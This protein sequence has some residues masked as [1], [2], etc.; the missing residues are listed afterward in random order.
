MPRYSRRGYYSRR[1]KRRR[2]RGAQIPRAIKENGISNNLI[3]RNIGYFQNASVGKQCFQFLPTIGY[4]ATPANSTTTGD[5][6]G[7]L[8]LF[9][10]DTSSTAITLDSLARH[11]QGSSPTLTDD[12]TASCWFRH[13]KM[14]Y[15]LSNQCANQIVFTLYLIKVRR[16]M[17][18]TPTALLTQNAEK[19]TDQTWASEFGFTNFQFGVEPTDMDALTSTCKIKNLGTR[20]VQPGEYFTLPKLTLM[21]NKRYKNEYA[22]QNSTQTVWGGQRMYLCRMFTPPMMATVSSVDN[23]HIGNVHMHI[24]STLRVRALSVEDDDQ[25]YAGGDSFYATAT[26]SVLSAINP[27]VPASTAAIAIKAVNSTNL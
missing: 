4:I 26:P 21:K 6:T 15:H 25:R 14:F 10:Y 12:A 24:I 13:L 17:T 20:L 1:R 5:F 2:F 16:N 22:S 11:I 23:T 8:P 27:V 19:Y 3:F 7:K 18:Q 9:C